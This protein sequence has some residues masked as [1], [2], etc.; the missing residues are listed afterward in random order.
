M[1]SKEESMFSSTL[2]ISLKRDAKDLE[3][4]RLSGKYISMIFENGY[5]QTPKWTRQVER[6]MKEQGKVAVELLF[7]YATCPKCARKYGKTQK[8]I[9]AKVV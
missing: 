5:G 4:E 8:V 6:Y 7:W 1:F 2:L 9:F 3:T